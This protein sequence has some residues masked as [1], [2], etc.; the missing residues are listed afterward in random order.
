MV[1]Q[2]MQ[3]YAYAQNIFLVSYENNPV[4]NEFKQTIQDIALLLRISKRTN[5]KE[6]TKWFNEA[7]E[8]QPSE[9]YEH[10][11]AKYVADPEQFGSKLRIL[12]SKF[13]AIQTSVIG[14]ARDVYPIH[15]LSPNA[16]PYERFKD[17]DELYFRPTYR[18]SRIETGSYFFEIYP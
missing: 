17:T 13:D 16:L 5:Q 10:N 6:F 2:K 3:R 11:F 15:I 12:N 1:L 7:W 9:D 8:N 14:I 18:R 4:I